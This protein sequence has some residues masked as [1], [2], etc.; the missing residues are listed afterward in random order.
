MPPF[1]PSSGGYAKVQLV[2]AAFHTAVCIMNGLSA[3]CCL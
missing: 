1:L 3:C 2:Y